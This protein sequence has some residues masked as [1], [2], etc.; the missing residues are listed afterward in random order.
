VRALSL[1]PLPQIEYHLVRLDAASRSSAIAL[2]AP[3]IVHAL[4]EE[5]RRTSLCV[6]SPP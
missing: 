6:A 3:E 1:S 2:I 5:D 4:E